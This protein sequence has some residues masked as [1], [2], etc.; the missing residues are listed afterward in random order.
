M[1]R[2]PALDLSPDPAT[3]REDYSGTFAQIR[4][5][6][7]NSHGVRYVDYVRQLPPV[8]W[9]VYV[10]IA[11]RY[12]A[13]IVILVAICLGQ[14]AGVS[15]FLLI[16]PGAILIAVRTPAAL[17]HE[18]AHWNL[19]GDRNRNDL[20]C[21]V[22]LS[23]VIALEI[24]SYR[25]VHFEHHRHLGTVHDT[26]HSYFL[27]LN[28]MFLLNSLLGLSAA[29]AL[30]SYGRHLGSRTQVTL[31]GENT[32]AGSSGRYL[33][34]IAS[35]V[36]HGSI[37]T[38][39]WFFGQTAAAGAWVL[40]IGAVLPFVGAT[41]QLLEHRRDDARPDVDYSK[42][43]QGACAR[44]FGDGI[45][46]RVIGS[47]GFNRH[48]LHHWEPQLSYTRLPELERFLA[49]TPIRT[50]LE[51]RRTTYSAVFRDFFSFR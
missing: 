38:G 28:M 37:V 4:G 17:I 27:P 26:E 22:L 51:Q 34:L 43:D 6:L 15:P 19:T 14:S 46:A 1:H 36:I 33:V 10:E 21:N 30:L 16:V 29:R 8:Y 50:V 48:L 11:G 7:T 41:R 35:V 49:D 9:H 44:I 25:K 31:S 23:W 42:T 2:N 18:A 3:S 39:L 32:S 47:A 12:A 5:R 20:I 24:K 13:C 40:G 45:F